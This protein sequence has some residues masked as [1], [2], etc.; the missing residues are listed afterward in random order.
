MK[1]VWISGANGHIGTALCAQLDRNRYDLIPTDVEDVDVTDMEAARAFAEKTRPDVIINC[2]GFNDEDGCETH[3]ER[4]FRVN[5]VAARNLALAADDLGAKLLQM[6]TDDV[7]AE[8]SH[9]PYNEFDTPCPKTLYG[10]SKLAGE[11]FVMTLCHR[12]VIVR[13]AWVYGI[14]QDF[15]S[16][17]LGCAR[18]P[19]CPW[20]AVA[21]DRVASPTGADDLAAAVEQ[22]MDRPALGIY[23]VVCQGHCSRYDFARE[24]LRDAHL[25]DQLVLHPIR[26]ADAGGAPSYTVLDNM[27]LR[28]DGIPQPRPWRTALRAYIEGL[29]P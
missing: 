10:R 12:Y 8:P 4:A 3:P 22:L 24:I 17:V 25:E 19:N 2:T 18:D 29:E 27:M 14:G 15:V 26:A 28:L 5:A 20:L 13:S 6:S 1:K 23:H 11:R 7:F 9:H 21:T 16:T